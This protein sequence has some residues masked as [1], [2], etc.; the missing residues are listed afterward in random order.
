MKFLLFGI[1]TK[2]LPRSKCR[3]AFWGGFWEG[4]SASTT[5][6]ICTHHDRYSGN[7]GSAWK[8]VGSYI[9][10]SMDHV[11]SEIKAKGT[12]DKPATKEHAV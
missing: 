4:A 2:G 10:E 1:D 12:A 7:L 6:Y 11:D 3:A 8:K 5:T 9:Y